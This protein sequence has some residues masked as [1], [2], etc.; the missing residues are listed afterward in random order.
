MAPAKRKSVADEH[1][2]KPPTKRSRFEA[3][4]EHK[5]KGQFE[6]GRDNAEPKKAS[7]QSASSET[8]TPAVIPRKEVPAFPRGGGGLLTPLEKKQIQIKASQDAL[9]EQNDSEDLFGASTFRPAGSESDDNASEN[10]EQA[11]Q[12]R[13]K[14]KKTVTDRKALV[15]EKTRRIEGL[16]HKVRYVTHV[17]KTKLTSISILCQKHSF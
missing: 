12:T 17:H 3:K 13:R 1:P 7:K 6:D 2:S 16:K 4:R 11:G 5:S 10:K 9:A 8:S 15:K 14:S